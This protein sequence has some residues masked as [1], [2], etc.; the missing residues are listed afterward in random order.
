MISVVPAAIVIDRAREE[1]RR[2]SFLEPG[3][4]RHTGEVEV[5]LGQPL[6]GQRPRQ[7]DDRLL[8]SGPCAPTGRCGGRR[9]RD[10]HALN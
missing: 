8:R 2:P 9:G 1:Q 6:A 5:G 3:D 10:G 4:G 7:L